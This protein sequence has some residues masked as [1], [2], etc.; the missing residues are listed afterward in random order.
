MFTGI[1]THADSLVTAIVVLT[2][3]AT[4]LRGGAALD[5]PNQDDQFLALL[6]QKGALRS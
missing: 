1:T 6:S 5:D 3:G 2:T 4:I